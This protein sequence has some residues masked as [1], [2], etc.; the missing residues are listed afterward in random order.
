MYIAGTRG[1]YDADGTQHSGRGSFLMLCQTDG[2]DEI[3][4]IVRTVALHQLGHFMM[5]TARARGH[6]ITVSGAYG[7]DGLPVTVPADVFAAAV[8]LPDRLRQAWAHGGGWNSAGGEAAEM[9][10][11]AIEHVDAL[12]A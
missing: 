2:S 5:G 4:A 6:S 11:W 10:A 1:Y 7:G 12:R 9:R 8:P 3:R